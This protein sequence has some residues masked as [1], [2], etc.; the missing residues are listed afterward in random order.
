MIAR[1]ASG[2]L[3][4]I[5]DW[6]VTRRRNSENVCF[7]LMWQ[8]RSCLSDTNKVDRK[9][10]FVRRIWCFCSKGRYECPILPPILIKLSTTTGFKDRNLQ[11][12]NNLMSFF[13]VLNSSEKHSNWASLNISNSA[14]SISLTAI[15]WRISIINNFRFWIIYS[16]LNI[17]VPSLKRWFLV[18]VFTHFQWRMMVSFDKTLRLDFGLEK[19]V[20]NFFF[21]F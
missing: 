13:K 18:I 1:H 15:L 21:N 17:D 14:C 3:L 11:C 16:C 4:I 12:F 9:C 2:K 7:R 6:G 10:S 20:S 19:I 8:W 5:G